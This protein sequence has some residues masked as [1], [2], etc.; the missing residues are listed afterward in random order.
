MRFLSDKTRVLAT[1]CFIPAA[2]KIFPFLIVCF[3]CFAGKDDQ[4]FY[5]I[6]PIIIRELVYRLN[7]DN[8]EVLKAAH[9]AFMALSTHVP[10]EELVKH[11]EYMKNLLAS[12]VSDARRRKGGVGDGEFLL[13]G[14][15]IPKGKHSRGKL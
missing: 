1:L 4:D 8:P 13:P 10:A 15:N 3:P 5:E 7:D 14:F 9:N 6:I 12:M 2:S 11:V